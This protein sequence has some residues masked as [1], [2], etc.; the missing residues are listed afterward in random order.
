[1]IR[2]SFLDNDGV[3]LSRTEHQCR[4]SCRCCLICLIMK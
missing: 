4:C 2:P 3:R 1:M